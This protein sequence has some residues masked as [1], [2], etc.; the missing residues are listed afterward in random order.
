MAYDL[1]HSHAPGERRRNGLATAGWV[2]AG[3]TSAVIL[4][5]A[6]LAGQAWFN[7]EMALIRMHGMVGGFALLGAVAST[8]IAVVERRRSGRLLPLALSVA[9][10]ALMLGQTALGMMGRSS[11]AAAALHIPN[12]ILV[13]MVS[14]V[15]VA[16]AAATNRPATQ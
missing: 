3:L 13:A 5:M 9:L 15:L 8:A 11:A 16:L 12:G 4:A 14:A 1:T 10:L 6:A 7:G 2:V